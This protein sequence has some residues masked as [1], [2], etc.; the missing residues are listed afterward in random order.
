MNLHCRA[1]KSLGRLHSYLRFLEPNRVGNLAAGHVG[2]QEQLH[3]SFDPHFDYVGRQKRMLIMRKSLPDRLGGIPGEPG[4]VTN[5]LSV[6]QVACNDLLNGREIGHYNPPSRDTLVIYI[7]WEPKNG[8]HRADFRI[9]PAPEVHYQMRRDTCRPVN[10]E[11]DRTRSC[12]AGQFA[13]PRYSICPLSSCW[14]CC[15]SLRVALPFC[16]VTLSAKRPPS[17][18]YP[19]SLTT[20]GDHI[21][22]RRLDLKLLQKEVAG[23]LGVDTTT[24]T[25]WEK[26][27]CQ[28]KLYLIPKIIRLL[29]YDPFAS[30]A[31]ATPGQRIK[32][33]RRLHGLSQKKLAK[34]LGIDP[35]TLARW[36][37]CMARSPKG[38]RIQVDAL[39][40]C[41]VLSVTHSQAFAN[42]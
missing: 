5:R 9:G 30:I 31:T 22:K 32:A 1:F 40:T 36:E 42:K 29:G 39:L 23:R 10:T 8:N 11:R 6:R 34:Q 20:L 37:K 15:H 3:R 28:P 24:V 2:L 4:N 38:L 33:F 35:T 12:I 17:R 14:C 41:A 18:A 7:L 27:R 26:N 25:N 13:K 19:V 21:R 16:S